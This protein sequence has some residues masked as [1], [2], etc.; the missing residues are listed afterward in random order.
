MFFHTQGVTMSQKDDRRKRKRAEKRKRAKERD[1]RKHSVYLFGATLTDTP[2][3]PP[4]SKIV[5]LNADELAALKPGP[6][7][8]ESLK[9]ET[10]ARIRTIYE[11]IGPYTGVNTLEEWEIGFMRDMHP[12]N[13]V[14][15]W[16]RICLAWQK[17]HL[18]YLE[19]T[20]RSK[21]YEDRLV[22]A[23][24]AISTGV[25]TNELSVPTNVAERLVACYQHPLPGEAVDGK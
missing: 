2:K 15:V 19:N 20:V 25:E 14:S 5:K 12:E 16:S 17:Y 24:V 9:P 21:S 6:I 23:L 22:A 11:L 8:H 7:R 18:L 10:L 13:E 3:P 1:R 4:K